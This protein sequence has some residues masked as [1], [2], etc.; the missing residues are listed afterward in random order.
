M[1]NVDIIVLA[2][3]EGTRMKSATPKVLHS[4]GGL[5][6]LEH[7]LRSAK[8]FGAVRTAVV[9]GPNVPAVE[10]FL[11]E[12][13]APIDIFVQTERLGT[14]HATMSAAKFFE[15]DKNANIVLFGDT[16]LIRPQTLDQIKSLLDGDADLVVQGFEP[17]S[18]TGYGR[19]LVKGGQLTA[20][21]EEKDATD[22]E[23][24]IGLCNA[25]AMGFAPGILNKLLKLL[26]NENAQSEYYLTDC[27]ELAHAQG[28]SV[29]VVKGDAADAAGINSRGQ[30]AAVEAIFQQRMRQQAMA[31]GVTLLAPETVHFCYDTELEADVTIEPNVVFGPKVIV[32]SG[33]IIKAFSHLEGAVIGEGALIGPFARLRPG[34]EL[35]EKT[36]VGN[37]VEIKGATIEKGSKINHLSYI[38]D[39]HIAPGV[40]VGAGTVTC[41]YDGFGKHR[42]TIGAD[43]FIGSGSLLVAPLEIGSNAYVATGSVITENVPSDALAFGRARQTNKDG[44]GAKLKA[45]LRA[46][47]EKASKAK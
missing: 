26:T 32:R 34:T 5:P 38:G 17:D 47:K 43:S 29:Q 8:A 11:K 42:T 33:A 31:N 22:T 16:P 44:R 37:F 13:P 10:G 40:N 39:A 25:G 45:E 4:V 2:A 6:M 9:I 24:K 3:G 19:L 18:P 36:K 1:S 20:I 23:R 46:A 14:G 7:V 21:R 41:N 35:G 15:D 27:V 12:H 30:L 28:L